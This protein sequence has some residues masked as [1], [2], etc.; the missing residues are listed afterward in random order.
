MN[1]K[2]QGL[3]Y[4][5]KRALAGL[6]FTL[7]WIVGFLALFF[8]PLAEL[9]MYSV[10]SLK[11]EIGH[12]EMN[13]TGFEHY[14]N[15]FISDEKFLPMLYTQLTEMLYR[16]PVILAFSL[17]IS[18]LLNNK[19]HGRTIVRAIFFIPV[20]AGSGG[21]VM[22]I[23][24]GDVMSESIMSGGRAG[25]LFQSFSFQQVLLES[26]VSNEIIDIYMGIVSGIFEL[27]WQS[28]LQIVLFIAALQNISPQLYEAARVE[29]ATA[30]EGFWNI[31]FPLI[32]PI[33]IV[34]LI[35]TI[36]DFLSD[37]SNNVIQYIMTLIGQFEYSYS[38]AI[39]FIY[40]L[41]VLIVVSVVYF[42]VDR[43]VVYTVN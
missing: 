16:I 42:I 34:N 26:G 38:S 2:K 24:N 4:K 18:I 41:V 43:V 9:F 20:I 21:I 25:M 33:L 14:K 8:R 35:Y 30:W 23:M 13:F 31:T 19:F 32:T 40:F 5:N 27:T 6:L 28:G 37:Y 11:V 12:L 39:S 29:G 1:N 7:P 36:I 3:S 17:F 15:I 22:S 10:S